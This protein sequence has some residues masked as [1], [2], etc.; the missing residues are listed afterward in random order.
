[1]MRGSEPG[2][3][4]ELEAPGSGVLSR[5]P[6]PGPPGGRRRAGELCGIESRVWRPSL[7]GLGI[8][9]PSP[10]PHSHFLAGWLRA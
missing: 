7:A 9:E 1:M 2:L 6:L 5:P 8:L 4:K 3:E 10:Q